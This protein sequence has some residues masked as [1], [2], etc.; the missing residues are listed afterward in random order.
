MNKVYCKYCGKEASSV[1]SLTACSCPRHPDGPNK[2]YILLLW[3]K[4]PI[5]VAEVGQRGDDTG[6]TLAPGWRMSCSG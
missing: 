3:D 6:R 5:V 1:M 4:E 2:G